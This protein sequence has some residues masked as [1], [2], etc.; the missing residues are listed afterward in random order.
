VVRRYWFCVTATVLT[1]ACGR[2]WAAGGSLQAVYD[3]AQKA[4]DAGDWDHAV[5]GFEQVLAAM[6]APSRSS[7]IVRARLAE[8]L[9]GEDRNDEAVDQAIQ[10]MTTLHLIGSGPDVELARAD[11]TLGDALSGA[12]AYDQAIQA[13]EQAKSFATGPD[14]AT[15][16]FQAVIGVAKS[17]M[18]TEPDLAAATADS[19]IE[20]K[21]AF[22]TRP[23]DEQEGVY[24]LRARAALNQGEAEQ[25]RHFIEKALSLE[26]GDLSRVSLA[27]METRGDAALIYA[28]LHRDE[29]THRYLASTGEGHMK[30]EDWHLGTDAEPPLCGPLI[31]PDDAAVVEFTIANNGQTINAAPVWVS[32]P[33]PMGVEFARAVRE[34]RWSSVEVAKLPLFWRLAL[35][36][37]LR[38]IERPPPLPLA[39]P[40]QH[41]THAWLA[42][43][44]AD[45]DLGGEDSPPASL[46]TTPTDGGDLNSTPALFRALAHASRD[47]RRLAIGEQLD[48]ML[49][50]NGAP[51]EVRALAASMAA[52]GGASWG[53][54]NWYRRRAA[55]LGA[56][57]PRFDAMDGG[58]R[59]AAWLRTEMAINLETAGDF[60]A[61]RAPLEAVVGLPVSALSEDD[62]IRQVAILHLSLL[63]KKA[64]NPG[65]AQARLSAAG[66]TGAKCD[67]LD[68]HPVQTGGSVLSSDVTNDVALW[69]FDGWVRESFDIAADGAVKDVR[70]VIAYPPLVYDDAT[71][72]GVSRFRYLAPS[73]N[74]QALGCNGQT[75]DVNFRAASR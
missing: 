17:A 74:G 46:A 6:P 33:G 28:K 10:A 26:G 51:P 71:R 44:G 36:I 58:A 29:L 35:R 4:F 32:R 22:A 53:W 68:V 9:L 66:L 56:V 3:Q 69:Q 25:A 13:Y 38:C 75:Y 48:N 42:S 57:L 65:A 63:D 24:T 20:D 61:A 41:A 1:L 12:L 21:A 11:L 8:A 50:Q 37:E 5:S 70:T 34:W 7:A 43:H 40:F 55:A 64:G 62:P 59:S 19:L 60:S 2:A 16:S 54:R 31:N 52:D 45:G 39:E 23:R 27:Q 49:R 73:Y 14:A 72:Q 15:E 30:S 67:L 18:V 47:D